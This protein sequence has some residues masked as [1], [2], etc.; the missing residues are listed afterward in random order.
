VA[1]SVPSLNGPR[2]RRTV[3]ASVSIELDN[4]RNNEAVLADLGDKTVTRHSNSLWQVHSRALNVWLAHFCVLRGFAREIGLPAYAFRQL[5]TRSG[6]EVRCTLYVI[7]CTLYGCP[8]WASMTYS[9][10]IG[11]R[12][13][14]GEPFSEKSLA[15]EDA[16]EASSN[17]IFKQ[18]IWAKV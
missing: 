13:D 15:V 14:W 6:R 18:L 12:D 7:L 2:R 8:G 5:V 16:V 10:H 9:L 1:N 17:V 3:L 11:D 4:A